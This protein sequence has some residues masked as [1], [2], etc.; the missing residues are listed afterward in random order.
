[1]NAQFAQAQEAYDNQL[2]PEYYED[3]TAL[4][5][6]HQRALEDFINDGYL[7]IASTHQFGYSLR[8]IMRS[9]SAA[10]AFFEE[11]PANLLTSFLRAHAGEDESK[12]VA[13]GEAL[14]EAC[15]RHA[16]HWISQNVN[17]KYGLSNE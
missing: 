17:E 10:D 11:V 14:A 9:Y 7:V 16:E 13:A 3:P 6:A 5:K 1:M 15:L 8:G 4:E 12:R 2:P